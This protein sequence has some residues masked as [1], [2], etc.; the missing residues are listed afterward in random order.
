M[1]TKAEVLNAL[2]L[3]EKYKEEQV[4]TIQELEI[5]ADTRSILILGLNTRELNCLKSVGIKTVGELLSVDRF[6]IRRYRNLGKKG[7]IN[8]NR[9]LKDFGIDTPEFRTW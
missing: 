2:N 5:K 8:I 6:E 9:K 1:I 7:I 3:I 4:Q